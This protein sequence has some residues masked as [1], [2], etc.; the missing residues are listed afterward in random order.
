MITKK[1]EITDDIT[2]NDFVVR[3]SPFRPTVLIFVMEDYSGKGQKIWQD[4]YK[5]DVKA[6]IEFLQENMPEEGN[7]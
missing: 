1:L 6:L 5:E 7:Q 2:C 3:K 4:L